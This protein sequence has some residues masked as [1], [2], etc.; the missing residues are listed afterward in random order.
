MIHILDDLNLIVML[1]ENGSERILSLILDD[2][3]SITILILDS[4]EP[5]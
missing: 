2:F 4:S 3:I 1:I 5:N